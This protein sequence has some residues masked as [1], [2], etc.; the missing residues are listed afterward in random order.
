MQR[1]VMAAELAPSHADG[2]VC[3]DKAYRVC[4]VGVEN[5]EEEANCRFSSIVGYWM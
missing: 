2:T 3:A 5:S 4:Q 1:R